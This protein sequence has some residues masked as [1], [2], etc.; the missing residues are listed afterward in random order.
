MDVFRLEEL[1]LSTD[2][3]RF[4]HKSELDGK[5]QKNLDDLEVLEVE[6]QYNNQ[7]ESN[8]VQEIV[9]SNE[10][11]FV[12]AMFFDA[13]V[14]ELSCVGKFLQLSLSHAIFSRL[15]GLGWFFAV[16]HVVC[17]RQFDFIDRLTLAV[18]RV[19]FP[20]EAGQEEETHDKAQ[21]L[22]NEGQIVRVLCNSQ[23]S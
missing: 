12:Q 17:L 10:G 11:A 23:E 18:K 6:N 7:A 8:C 14:Y 21:I 5:S 15:F 1:V 2:D 4:C 13:F 3:D 20:Y 22:V 9:A 19:E 16:Y